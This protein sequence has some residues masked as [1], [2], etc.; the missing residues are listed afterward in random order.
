MPTHLSVPFPPFPLLFFCLP[1][2]YHVRSSEQVHVGDCSFAAAGPKLWNS[3]PVH[4]RQSNQRL[5]QNF[6]VQCLWLHDY[7]ASDYCFFFGAG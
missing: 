1:L 7:G 4:L 3:L 5:G 2:L 6:D